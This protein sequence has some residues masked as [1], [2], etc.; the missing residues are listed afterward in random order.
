M[1]R[2]LTRTI[3]GSSSCPAKQNSGLRNGAKGLRQRRLANL[4]GLCL[5]RRTHLKR[6]LNGDR[7]GQSHPART[8][9]PVLLVE[10]LPFHPVLVRRARHHIFLELVRLLG[11]YCSAAPVCSVRWRDLRADHPDMES[12]AKC[13]EHLEP[14]WAST[15]RNNN[16]S[17]GQTRT[18]RSTTFVRF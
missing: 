11:R 12:G 7:Q 17:P 5:H 3:P 6:H 1:C 4:L 13:G 8:L 2:C 10:Q 18:V 15:D 16:I 14:Y 9:Q